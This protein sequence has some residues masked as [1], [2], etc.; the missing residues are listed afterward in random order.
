MRPL[1]PLAFELL[2]AA[3]LALAACTREGGGATAGASAGSAEALEKAGK[4]AEAAGLHRDAALRGPP[5][6]SEEAVKRA[7]VAYLMADRLS[8]AESFA[9]EVLRRDRKSVV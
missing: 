5:A 4:W 3:L 6:G 2:A 7:I 9:A 8:D 1:T